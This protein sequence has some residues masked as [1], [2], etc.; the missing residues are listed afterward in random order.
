MSQRLT[1]YWA[2]VTG[3]SS[4]I[5]EAYARL[6]AAEGASV[7]LTARRRERLEALGEDLR[8]THGVAYEAIPLD[9]AETEAPAK[10]FAAATRDGRSI[11]MLI[12]NAGLGPYGHFLSGGT[13]EHRV[14][15]GVNVLALTDLAHRFGR[16]M[17]GQK[18]PCYIGN[19]GSLAGLQ[20]SPRF[21]V[22]SATKSY[23]R[24]FSEILRYELQGTNISVS[25]LCPGGT[26]TEFAS[27]N[28]QVLHER[29]RGAI[30][31]AE[32]VA[33]A[34]LEG[35]FRGKPI[36]VPGL[37]NKMAAF[38]PRIVPRGVALSI[39]E[40]A[41]NFAVAEKIETREEMKV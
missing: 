2:V 12:N 28:N 3:A 24:V 9:I 13:V 11:G 22:Y 18:R 26:E 20:G 4:G 29:G 39:A 25:C 38:L 35:L 10:L 41:M 15:I 27:T 36:V 1:G 16:H 7:V 21:A 34:G 14:T 6:L 5:G 31:T 40:R 8:H 17:L 30:M 23:V 32:A 33:R 37:V 19:V